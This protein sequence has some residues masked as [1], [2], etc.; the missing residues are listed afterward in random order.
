MEKCGK[1]GKNRG[2]SDLKNLKLF[3]DVSNEILD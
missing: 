2:K 3:S 1:R